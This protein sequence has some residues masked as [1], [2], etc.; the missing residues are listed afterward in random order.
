MSENIVQDDVDRLIHAGYT[1]RD[2]AGWPHWVR[3]HTGEV[4]TVE[5]LAEVLLRG[6]S[7]LAWAPARLDAA[8]RLALGRGDRGD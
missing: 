5:E 2:Y 4:A 6:Q 3:G 7:T 1:P 8:A